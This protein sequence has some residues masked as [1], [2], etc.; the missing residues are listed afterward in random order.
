MKIKLTAIAKA[1]ARRIAPN[2][3]QRRVK[4]SYAPI[5][6]PSKPAFR[7]D[8]QRMR[9][10]QPE[11]AAPPARLAPAITNTATHDRPPGEVPLRLEQLRPRRTRAARPRRG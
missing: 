1:A 4:K 6:F 9:I 2:E 7:G 8:I 10:D 3:P 5:H 11:T